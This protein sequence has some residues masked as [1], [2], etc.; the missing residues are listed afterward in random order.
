MDTDCAA[1]LVC[2][3]PTSG[4]AMCGN[5]LNSIAF[6]EDAT[7]VTTDAAA[8]DGPTT[9]A[10][11]SESSSPPPVDAAAADVTP[12][13][14]EAGGGVDGAPSPDSGAGD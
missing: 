3:P 7:T 6:T 12:P 2:L 13:A 11:A 5:N 8:V 9:D 1:G 14:M 4:A 10:A